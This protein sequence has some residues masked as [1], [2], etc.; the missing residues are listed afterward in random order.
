[1]LR[2][3][4]QRLKIEISYTLR[5]AGFYNSCFSLFEHWNIKVVRS[6]TVIKLHNFSY[7]VDAGSS[8]NEV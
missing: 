6:N 1:M 2:A 5:L 8:N 7:H 3:L 4:D